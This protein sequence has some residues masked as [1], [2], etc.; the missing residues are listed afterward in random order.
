M[1]YELIPRR[2][3]R[4]FLVLLLV[5]KLAISV[6]N[7][8]AFPT[9]GSYD[10]RHHAWR[11][12][13]AG[14]EM[15]K[16][17]YNPPLYYLPVL[18]SVSPTA[19]VDD[20]MAQLRC[21]NVGYLAVFYVA[22]VFFIFPRML[23]DPRA[24]TIAGIVLLSLP[25]YQK[26]AAMVHPDNLLMALSAASFAFWLWMARQPKVPLWSSLLLG[27]LSGLAGMTR[28]FAVVPVLVTW[29]LNLWE[30]LR[31]AGR[32]FFSASFLGRAAAVTLL[33]G[34][35][36]SGWYAYRYAR[37]GHLMNAYNDSYVAPYQPLKKGFDFGE[38]Y[39][40]FYYSK[41]LETPNRKLTGKE[42][43][44]HNPMAN[45]F[46]TIFY[47]ETWGDHWLYFSGT[48]NPDGKL[49]EKRALLVVALPLTL[50][51]VIGF[52]VGVG[53]SLVH[54]VR[55]REWVSPRTAT[56]AMAVGGI[57]LYLYWQSGAG[58]LPGKNSS[59]K[60]LYVAY[61]IPYLVAVALWFRP[62]V[63]LYNALV[64]LSLLVYAAAL[65]VSIYWPAAKAASREVD[66][67]DGG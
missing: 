24:A 42:K 1:P 33:I 50:F 66:E 23:P 51:L 18:P 52:L 35:M 38:Y 63:R 59:I 13:S 14:L 31:N 5:L 39:T 65:P 12:K 46:F 62:R 2:S 41:L 10:H 26:S 3:A 9:R 30:A 49:W 25:G 17:A 60:F 28:P 44:S 16:M 37:T 6:W 67:A 40:T 55:E 53:R 11:A 57:A 32:R 61:A 4:A 47:S 36:S 20:L 54:A 48:R 64:A 34:A 22:W 27:L 45:T 15:G 58:L 56:V 43:P 8:A 7:A 19:K 21:T 29:A